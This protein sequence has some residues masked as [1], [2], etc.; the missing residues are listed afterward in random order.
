M[1]TYETQIYDSAGVGFR[2]V[3]PIVLRTSAKCN[4]FDLLPYKKSLII[5][6]TRDFLIY[7]RLFTLRLQA[8]RSSS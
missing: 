5:F 2:F 7:K 3:F 6:I 1:R 4:S 8:L